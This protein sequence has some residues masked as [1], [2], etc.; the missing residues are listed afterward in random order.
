MLITSLVTFWLWHWQCN[1]YCYLHSDLVHLLERSGVQYKTTVKTVIL[2]ELW[3]DSA[4]AAA[5]DGSL[6][7]HRGR[8]WQ[9][10]VRQRRVSTTRCRTL[11]HSAQGWVCCWYSLLNHLSIGCNYWHC[12]HTW[13]TRWQRL[14]NA[15]VSICLSVCL[16]HLSTAACCCSGFAAVGLVGRR[17]RFVVII[18]T[19]RIVYGRVCVM[20]QYPS[21]CLSVSLSVH[22]SV[23]PIYRLLHT[24]VVGLLLWAWWAGDID[25]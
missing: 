16:S 18:D 2:S 24:S 11:I 13:H 20:V 5:W 25:W 15:M 17:Y 22:L 19:A 23:C 9:W 10:T 3:S 12:W 8:P 21:I 4:M 14:R 7:G 1:C 6:Y